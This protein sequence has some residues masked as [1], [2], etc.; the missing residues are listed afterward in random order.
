M[1]W[2]VITAPSARNDL[3]RIVRFIGRHNSDAAARIGY[4]LITHADAIADF[5]DMG[6][7]VPGLE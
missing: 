2:K 7:T 1:G 5:P 6:R 4:E 3:E